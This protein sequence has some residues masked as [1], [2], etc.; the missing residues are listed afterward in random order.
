MESSWLKSDLLIRARTNGMPWIGLGLKTWQMVVVVE[1]LREIAQKVQPKLYA[2]LMKR[3]KKEV[4]AQRTWKRVEN[5][6]SIANW[7]AA[8]EL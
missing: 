8:R 1:V 5:G 7:C 4:E 6:G 2:E 3:R